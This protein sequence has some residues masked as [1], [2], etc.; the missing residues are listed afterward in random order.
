MENQ[1]VFIFIAGR[2]VDQRHVLYSSERTFG[3][4]AQKLE[5]LIGKMVVGPKSGQSG[6]GVESIQADHP[7]ARPIMIASDKYFAQIPHPFGHLI[8]IGAVAHN[9]PQVENLIVRGR[10]LQAGI[11]RLL[12][13]MNIG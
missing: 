4:L 6:I 2:T 7:R 5:V 8:G 3:K 12:V 9:V 1:D 13:G 10:S 11:Q